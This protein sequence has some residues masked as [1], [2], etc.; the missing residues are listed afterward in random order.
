MQTHQD[1]LDRIKATLIDLKHHAFGSTLYVSFRISKATWDRYRKHGGLGML[2]GVDLSN[3]L[4]RIGVLNQYCV[5]VID[6]KRRAK[7]GFKTIEVTYYLDR[8]GY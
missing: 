8:K 6:D 2:Y 1:Y 4:G 7:D 3:Y 5:P